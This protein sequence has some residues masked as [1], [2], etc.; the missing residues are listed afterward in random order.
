MPVFETVSEKLWH[1]VVEMVEEGS[2]LGWLRNLRSDKPSV[3]LSFGNASKMDLRLSERGGSFLDFRPLSMRLPLIR[4]GSTSSTPHS[5]PGNLFVPFLS[6]GSTEAQNGSPATSQAV[7]ISFFRDRQPCSWP[8]RRNSRGN[9]VLSLRIPEK[10]QRAR[11]RERDSGS[12][13]TLF[14]RCS[15]SPLC[16]GTLFSV[17]VLVMETVKREILLAGL[18]FLSYHP[19]IFHHGPNDRL[20]PLLP[21]PI[22]QRGFLRTPDASGQDAFGDP[23]LLH[24]LS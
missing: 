19:S 21:R 14:L 17:S 18:V 13:R 7:C 3:A 24:G 4:I 22:R 9:P 2:R 10:F 5:C 1:L 23:D 20:F 15:L 12:N 11:I 8:N 6:S 16:P